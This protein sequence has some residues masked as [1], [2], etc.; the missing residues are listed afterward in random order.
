M[1]SKG[2]NVFPESLGMYPDTSAHVLAD[3][4][5]DNGLMDAG[6][7]V[8][9][10]FGGVNDEPTSSSV[11]I[12]REVPS[13]FGYDDLAKIAFAA[14]MVYVSDGSTFRNGHDLNIRTGQTDEGAP[15]KYLEYSFTGQA[16]E[17]VLS[18]ADGLTRVFTPQ[19]RISS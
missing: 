9:V 15:K 18:A 14:G 2:F 17:H 11:V 3:V 4:F 1:V 6:W 5:N 7:A 13:T 12:T 16:D 19:P 8:D 10:I